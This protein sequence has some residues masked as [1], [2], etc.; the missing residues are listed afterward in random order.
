[1]DDVIRK[2]LTKVHTLTIVGHVDLSTISLGHTAA[3]V[4]HATLDQ[5]L[6]LGSEGAAGA[7]DGH[8]VSD[9]VVCIATIDGATGQHTVFQRILHM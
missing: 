6:S 3:D 5:L 8:L 2:I 4:S 1:M 9:D 7:A